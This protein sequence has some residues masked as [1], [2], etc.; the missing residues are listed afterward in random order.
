MTNTIPKKEVNYEI[1]KANEEQL[2]FLLIDNAF[3]TDFL[4]TAVYEYIENNKK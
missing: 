3:S 1:E 2:R 4:I